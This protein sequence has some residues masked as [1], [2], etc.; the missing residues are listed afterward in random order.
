MDH[1]FNDLEETAAGTFGKAFVRLSGR[2]FSLA[3]G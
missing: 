2:A 3:S 1:D